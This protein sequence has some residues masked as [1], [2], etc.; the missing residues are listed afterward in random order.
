MNPADLLAPLSGQGPAWAVAAF[1]CYVC[2]KLIQR[3]L[4]SH[5][6]RDK[7]FIEALTALTTKVD[8]VRTDVADLR[9]DLGVGRSSF[10]V[11][12]PR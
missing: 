9:R 1:A 10:P 6:A 5:D 7:A 11:S 4:K 8:A 2:W 3:L 12:V